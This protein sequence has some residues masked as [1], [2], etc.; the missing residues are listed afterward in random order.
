MNRRDLATKAYRAAF[1]LRAEQ[2][3]EQNAALCP[4]DSATELG[5]DVVFAD[6]PSL[7]AMYV[8]D[9]QPYVIVAADRPPGRQRFSG[10]HEL[11][12]HVFG[13]GTHVSLIDH[14]SLERGGL[15][16]EEFLV[17]AFAGYL[18]LPASAVS[19]AF[20][21]RG[22]NPRHAVP[23]Q[24]YT[25]AGL[26]G[27]SFEGLITQC[28]FLKVLGSTQAAALRAVNL[29]RLRAAMAGSRIDGDLVIVDE[30]A[31][32][33]TIDL[34]VGDFL[35]TPLGVG[36][37]ND[38]LVVGGESSSGVLMQAERPGLSGIQRGLDS[39]IGVLRIARRGFVGRAVYR[40]LEDPGDA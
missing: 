37:A 35:L 2:G 20:S 38:A 10:A 15:P 29:P 26:L 28:I 33:M 1:K 31:L 34:R 24:F 36:P 18:L 3:R 40:H 39:S 9:D 17:Q 32:E 11:G 5:I 21:V 25:I 13:H 8:G 22:W 30:H 14:A 23:E 19:Y 27:V 6:I 12:H 7:E 16:D 4:Y